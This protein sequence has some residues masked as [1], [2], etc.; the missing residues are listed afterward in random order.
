MMIEGALSRMSLTNRTTSP[1]RLPRAYSARKVPARM[2]VGVPTSV[3]MRVIARLPAIALRRP[4]LLPGGGVIWVNRDGVIA[5]MPLIS[6]VPSTST[7]HSNPKAVAATDSPMI[8]QLLSRRRAYSSIASASRLPLEP[9]QQQF[10]QCQH[11]EGDDE[12]KKAQRDQRRQ[13]KIAD[14]LGEFVGERRRN[15]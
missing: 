6:S 7:S 10:G 2:P 13:V 1:N 8:S 4:P 5:P 11:D 15:R 3:A 14:R 9:D 12:Q